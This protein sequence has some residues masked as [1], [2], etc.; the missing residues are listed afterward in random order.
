M[1]SGRTT[2]TSCLLLLPHGNASSPVPSLPLCLH[3]QRVSAPSLAQCQCLQCRPWSH[4]FSFKTMINQMQYLLF[5]LQPSLLSW[6]LSLELN[7]CLNL[8]TL[9]KQNNHS[10]KTSLGSCVLCEPS[11]WHPSLCSETPCQSHG[12]TL[13]SLTLS[14]HSTPPTLLPPPVLILLESSRK[15]FFLNA[16]I[17][18]QCFARGTSW[19]P[20][21]QWNIHSPR[22]HLPV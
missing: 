19:L 4:L 6:L 15:T 5:Y 13:H 21:R 16:V 3:G 8:W 18:Q 1:P 20:L 2:L 10:R 11:L 22:N 7:K 17:L 12:K 9:K 14:F